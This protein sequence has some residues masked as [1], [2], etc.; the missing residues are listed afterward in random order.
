M[1]HHLEQVASE[2]RRR[3][4]D[5]LVRGLSDPRVRGMVSV[6]D[7][8]VAPDLSEAYV[9]VSVLPEEQGPR[10]AHPLPDDDLSTGFRSALLQPPRQ[11]A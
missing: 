3:L 11:L 6:T 4:Q 2:V 10:L 9:K 7:V 8:K 1:S 5:L